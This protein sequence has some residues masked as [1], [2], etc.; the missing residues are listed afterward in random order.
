MTWEEKLQQLGLT[1]QTA[2]N[3]VR[4]AI[5]EL[6]SYEKALQSAQKKLESSS[7]SERK[8]QQ[9]E[10]EVSTYETA[11]EAQQGVI[12]RKMEVWDKNKDRY[13]QMGRNLKPK[14]G[15]QGEPT[16]GTPPAEPAGGTP[17]A[18]PAGGTPPAEPAGGTPPAEPAKST[19]GTG[20]KVALF[21]LIGILS[22]GAYNYFKNNGE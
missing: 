11:I 6:R 22:F 1:E 3:M 18:E 14:T 15:K 2:P 8:R 12:L 19:T 4:K 21:L 5:N 7:L 10:E 9:L 16:G 13:A 17:P 20:T